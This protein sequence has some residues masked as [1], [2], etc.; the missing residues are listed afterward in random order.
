MGQTSF[1]CDPDLEGKVIQALN[2][3]GLDV[4]DVAGPMVDW[5]IVEK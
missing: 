3:N 2:D 1:Q 4:E 5:K